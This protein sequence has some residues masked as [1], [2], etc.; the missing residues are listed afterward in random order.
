MARTVVGTSERSV[1]N[2]LSRNALSRE[3]QMRALSERHA[4][5]TRRERE[6][7]ALVVAGRLNKQ[8]AAELGISEITFKAHRGMVMRKM[9][10]RTLP[11]LVHMGLRLGVATPMQ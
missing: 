5:L 1:T 8:V 4:S 2:E 11:A 6:V 7:M 9:K 10:A 3:S